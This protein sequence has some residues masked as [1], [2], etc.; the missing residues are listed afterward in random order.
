MALAG[1]AVGQDVVSRAWRKV[2]T[3]WEAWNTR[4]LGGEDIVQLILDGTVVKA[5]IDNKATAIPIL[6]AIGVR[7]DGQKVLIGLKIMG[8]ETAA[9]WRAF[10]QDLTRAV[11]V[12]LTSWSSTG[13]PGWRRRWPSSGSRPRSSDAPFTSTATVS[14]TCRKG[15]TTN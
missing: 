1:A 4:D 14:R 11:C 13:R 10:L 15:C 3:D 12:S 9:A 7:H 5:W 2:K 8:G 6:V